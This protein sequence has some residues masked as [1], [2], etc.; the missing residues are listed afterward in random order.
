MHGFASIEPQLKEVARVLE[1]NDWIYLRKIALPAALPDI[2]TGARISFA[3]ALILA[4]VV[5]MRRSRGLDRI[6]CWR[7]AF[8]EAPSFMPGSSCSAHSV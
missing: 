4:V 1:R 2:F 8:S 7:S 6:S 3:V 5:K